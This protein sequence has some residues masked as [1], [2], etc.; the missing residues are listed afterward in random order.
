MEEEEEEEEEEENKF[1]NS[2][3]TRTVESTLEQTNQFLPRGKS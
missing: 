1:T 3:K 2:P